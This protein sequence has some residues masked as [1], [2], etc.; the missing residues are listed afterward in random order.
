MKKRNKNQSAPF[1]GKV[2]L[3]VIKGDKTRTE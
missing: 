1:K 2:A 3:A